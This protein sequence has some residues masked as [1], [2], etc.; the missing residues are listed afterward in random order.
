MSAVGGAGALHEVIKHLYHLNILVML[1]AQPVGSLAA[2][3]TA[4]DHNNILHTL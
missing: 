4:A 3:D 1:I 2:D